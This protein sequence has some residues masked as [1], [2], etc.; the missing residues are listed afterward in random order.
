MPDAKY[1]PIKNELTESLTDSNGS[2]RWVFL[3]WCRAN[4]SSIEPAK[5]KTTIRTEEHAL[6]VQDRQPATWC[7]HAQ[8]F[9]F[10]AETCISGWEALVWVFRQ[11]VPTCATCCWHRFKFC[12]TSS[13]IK[14]GTCSCS[15]FFGVFFFQ[16]WTF[17][18]S[19]LERGFQ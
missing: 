10:E 14:I 8:V 9:G 15:T 11:S 12:V 2:H 5:P 19:L 13:G 3:L 1:H 18:R 16:L 6:L 7:W 4:A 17:S